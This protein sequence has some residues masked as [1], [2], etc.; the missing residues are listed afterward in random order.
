MQN[1]DFR[2]INPETGLLEDIDEVR[3]AGLIAVDFVKRLVMSPGLQMLLPMPLKVDIAGIVASVETLLTPMSQAEYMRQLALM[4]YGHISPQMAFAIR[5]RGY[6]EVLPPT[7]PDA[8]KPDISD[9]A[10][11]SDDPLVRRSALLSALVAEDENKTQP[12]P[13]Q[14]TELPPDVEKLLRDLGFDD[15]DQ[16]V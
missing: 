10:L 7:H 8:P 16:E 3:A 4:V 6:S 15:T 13:E 14:H 12:L 2:S 5:E 9:V 11:R 1:E